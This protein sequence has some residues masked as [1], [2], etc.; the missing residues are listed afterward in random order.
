MLLSQ[1]S[2]FFCARG[3]VLTGNRKDIVNR[4]LMLGTVRT[5]YT[6]FVSAEGIDNVSFEGERDRFDEPAFV[7][8]E[9]WT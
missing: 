8:E 6:D 7:L 5:S 4:F 9:D 3:Q 2:E 1:P